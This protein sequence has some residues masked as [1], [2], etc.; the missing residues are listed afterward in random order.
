MAAQPAEAILHLVS[1][2]EAD[3]GRTLLEGIDIRSTREGGLIE[4]MV[5]VGL[6]NREE[7]AVNEAHVAELRDSIQFE[8]SKGGSTGQLSPVL[9]AHVPTKDKF[10]IIDGHHPTRY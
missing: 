4:A 1:A 5:P 9:L 2:E 10:V 7:V 6:I 8:A 3:S